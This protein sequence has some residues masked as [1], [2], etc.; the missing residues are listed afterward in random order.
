MSIPVP[1][2]PLDEASA[3]PVE[4]KRRKKQRR[5]ATAMEYLV[6]ISMIL[7]VVIFTVQSVGIKTG[8]L[9]GK[10]ANATNSTIKQGP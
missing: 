2:A 6:C 7:L 5:G 3:T 4:A 9:F 1:P 8:E 10:N